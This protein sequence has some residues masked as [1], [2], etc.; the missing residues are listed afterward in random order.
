M[1]PK[2]VLQCVFELQALPAG[3][4]AVFKTDAVLMSQSGLRSTLFSELPASLE[5]QTALGYNAGHP[6]VSK[7]QHEHDNVC[8]PGSTAWTPTAFG[9]VPNLSTG[10]LSGCKAVFNIENGGCGVGTTRVLRF[11]RFF[12][13]VLWLLKASFDSSRDTDSK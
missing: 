8:A 2:L 10:G 6:P 3:L 4:Q 7:R 12:F 13:R 1:L 9:K 11:R 5:L